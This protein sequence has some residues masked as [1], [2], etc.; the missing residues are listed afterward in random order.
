MNLRKRIEN[1]ET[2]LK[3]DD[4][5]SYPDCC[6]YPGTQTINHIPTFVLPRDQHQ[7]DELKSF[8]EKHPDLEK[9]FNVIITS[10]KRMGMEDGAD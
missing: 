7:Y 9:G 8:F 1:I 4:T 5:L 3:N 2:K 6:Y 10:G